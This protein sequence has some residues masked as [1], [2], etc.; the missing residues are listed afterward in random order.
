[1]G[2]GMGGRH[3]IGQAEETQLCDSPLPAYVH[4]SGL[5]IAL[6]M[7][8]TKSTLV[9]QLAPRSPHRDGGGGV[10]RRQMETPGL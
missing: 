8:V 4:Q 2:M 6:T 3:R 7:Y 10:G 5:E 9:P 1:M